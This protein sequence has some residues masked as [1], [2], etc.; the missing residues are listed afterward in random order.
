MRPLVVTS[1]RFL[2]HKPKGYHPECPERVSSCITAI[3]QLDSC[4]IRLPSAEASPF[5]E[6]FALE[7]IRQAHNPAYVNQIRTLCSRGAPFI[8]PWDQDTYLSSDTFEQCVLAQSAWLDCVNSV[9]NDRRTSFAL[10]RPPG[11]HAGT[12]NG[13]GFCIFNF[14]V[15]AAI[16]ATNHLQL[17]R[18]AILDFDV[19][20]GNGIAEMISHRSNIRYCSLHEDSLFPLGQGSAYERGGHNNILN[21]PLRSGTK[22]DVYKKELVERAIPFLLEFK[23][24]L[25]IVSAGYGRLFLYINRYKSM[26]I[27]TDIIS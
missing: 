10:T 5:C 3:E 7:V 1:S 8:S 12:K 15:G 11:H 24:D 14:A 16:Y 4:D 6:S 20:Y 21:I 26:K 2:S 25:V 27:Y 13:M 9:V 23:P 22:W 18:V 17:N 19:H